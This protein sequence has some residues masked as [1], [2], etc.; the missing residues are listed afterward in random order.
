MPVASA[1]ELRLRN[2]HA[3]ELHIFQSLLLSSAGT[4][5][6]EAIIV[7]KMSKLSQ[8]IAAALFLV[9]TPAAAA[10]T[11]DA[12]VRTPG[13]YGTGNKEPAKTNLKTLAVDQLPQQQGQRSDAQYGNSGYYRGVA[14]RD[15]IA[16]YNPPAQVDLLLLH[17]HNGMIV[18]LPFRDDKAMSRLEPLVALGIGA[19][20]QGPFKAEFPPITARVEGYADIRKVEFG[21]NKLVVKERWHPDVPEAAQAE[22]S[23]WAT[24]DSL[25]GIEF[26]ESN[27]YYR[28]FIPT[29]EVRPGFEVFRQSCQYCHGVRKVGANF[30]WDYAQPIEL[31]TYRSDPARL[32]YH[33]HYRVEYTH[34]YSQMPALKHV[35]EDQANLLWRWMKSVTTA[36]M[37][38][39]TP[40][41]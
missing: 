23:P 2:G 10:N 32:Y 25:T 1:Q 8:T 16:Q 34:T 7:E 41:H 26:A 37:T 35:T 21:G 4:Q 31:H 22:F 40:T 12:W 20:A 28:Q 18:P 39:Y 14:L 27:A 17:F 19:A 30:G 29:A 5:L 24:I 38:R 11:V 13:N 36:P 15:L 6:A 3:Q 33:I 9:T